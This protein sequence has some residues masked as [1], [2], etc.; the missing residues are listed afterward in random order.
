VGDILS[1]MAQRRAAN[2]QP[3]IVENPGSSQCTTQHQNA[4]RGH[5]DT[6]HARLPDCDNVPAVLLFASSII[7]LLSSSSTSTSLST[8]HETTIVAATV[9]RRFTIVVLLLGSI[10]S[11]RCDWQQQQ[12]DHHDNDHDNECNQR[13]GLWRQLF[14][15][16][17]VGW[18]VGATS[19]SR[20]LVGVEI[21]TEQ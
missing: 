1:P 9:D 11:R 6:Q 21:S 10:G 2:P 19:H 17:A 8:Q 7:H 5:N 3:A 4:N 20:V 12:R 15:S 18:L 13:A 16:H 14:L